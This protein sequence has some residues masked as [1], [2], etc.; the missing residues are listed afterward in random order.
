MK[1]VLFCI[2][3]CT[4]VRSIISYFRYRKLLTFYRNVLEF[5]Y[6]YPDEGIGWYVSV[7]SA[8]MKCQKYADAHKYLVKSKEKFNDLKQYP[9]LAKEVDVNIEFCKH[10]IM[11]ASSLL[12]N[13]NTSWWH[14]AMVYIFG[15]PHTNNLSKETK[16]K[17]SSW[18]YAGKP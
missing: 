9:I 1:V 14:Y 16:A 12:R 4:F 3:I 18:V 15:T 7:A 5:L 6:R 13:R 2:I 17:V 11:G 10:P 8:L